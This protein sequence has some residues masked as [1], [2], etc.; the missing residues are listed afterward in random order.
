MHMRAIPLFWVLLWTWA[1]VNWIA[2]LQNHCR[3]YTTPMEKVVA[4]KPGK[5]LGWYVCSAEM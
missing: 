2:C 5:Y 4:E 3:G 1:R